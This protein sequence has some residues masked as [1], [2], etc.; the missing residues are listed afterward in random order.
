VT[1]T[2][3]FVAIVWDASTGKALTP[4]MKHGHQVYFAAFS[5]DGRYLATVCGDRT[6]RVW[7]AE[8]GKP[9][10]P[11]FLHMR[12]ITKAAFLDGTQR[13]LTWEPLWSQGWVWDISNRPWSVEDWQRISELYL[14]YRIE[15][16]GVESFI[17]ASQLE[18]LYAQLRRDFP[19]AFAVSPEQVV[20]WHRGIARRCERSELWASAAFH[21]RCL[22]QNDQHSTEIRERLEEVLTKIP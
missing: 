18:E 8:T 6:A 4:P 22:L 20:A 2:E 3:N 16:Y 12:S 11:P 1:T 19:E 7:N 14:G 13:L 10:S 21:Y 5:S 15:E 9:L 17:T